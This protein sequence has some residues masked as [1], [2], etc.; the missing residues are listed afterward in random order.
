MDQDTN[1]TVVDE[2][3]KEE[4]TEQS[5]EQTNP[6]DV[7][8]E[9]STEAKAETED[10]SEK[11]STEEETHD[12]RRM[13]KF[14]NRAVAA[15]TELQAL[16][17]QLNKQPVQVQQA[18]A[19]EQ[20]KSDGEYLAAAVQFEVQKQ[21]PILQQ[22]LQQ[23]TKTSV[24]D[25]KK[26]YKD[27]DE[28]MEDAASVTI[29]DHTVKAVTQSPL[30]EHL[31]YYLTKN[32]EKAQSL[33]KMAPERAIAEI[34]KMEAHI[35]STLTP[36]KKVEVS[37]AKTPI[38]PVKTTGSSGKVDVNKLSD[39]DWFKLEQQNKMAKLKTRFK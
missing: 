16:K 11:K 30:F 3:V 29:P 10:Q 22:S 7:K 32:P 1:T 2:P 26:V 23:D 9:T 33:W 24:E 34:G 28:V 31:K 20:F 17:A 19:R 25:V 37:K 27:Y 8:E 21:I 14:I 15:E 4:L 6:E 36:S 12:V 5:S 13:K 38:S 39:R 18:P 35:E